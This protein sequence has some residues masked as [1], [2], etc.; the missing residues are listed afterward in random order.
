MNHCIQQRVELRE[1]LHAA[2]AAY[3]GPFENRCLDH[4]LANILHVYTA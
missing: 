1:M 3:P 2:H 4:P